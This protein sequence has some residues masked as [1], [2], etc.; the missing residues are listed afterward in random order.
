MR[1]RPV[2]ADVIL[3]KTAAPR[4]AI[5]A[6]TQMMQDGRVAP[7][8]QLTASRNAGGRAVE[9]SLTVTQRIFGGPGFGDGLW[10]RRDGAGRVL[11]RA[12]E[13]SRAGG[14]SAVATGSYE[15]PLAGGRLKANG[16]AR[17]FKGILDDD[18]VL[19][20]SGE[21]YTL[22]VV[23]TFRQVE[24]GLRYERALGKRTTLEAQALQRFNAHDQTNHIRRP[25]VVSDFQE[26]DDQSESVARATVRFKKDE[27]LTLETSGEGALNVLATDTTFLVGGAASPLPNADI[28]VTERRGEVGGLVTWKPAPRYGVTAG[29]R[30]ETST[31]EAER[32]VALTRSL[33][34]LKPR[35]V[36]SWS[37]AKD[38]QIR[39]RVEREIGQINFFNFVAISEF[40]SGTVRAGNP[41]LRPQRAWVGEAVLERQ[42]WD[43]A[44]IVLTARQ[45]ALTDVVDARAVGTAG[46]VGIGNIGDGSETDLIAT[47]TF[48]LKRFGL[49][50]AM[51][52]GTVTRVISRVTDPT[53]GERR[54]IWFN[55]P[56]PL[57]GELHF[58]YD[59]PQRKLNLGFDAF[60]NGP[61]TLYR[62]AGTEHAGVNARLNAF[63]EYRYRPN[64]TI[65]LEGMNVTGARITQTIAYYAGARHVSPL[66]YEDERTLGLRPSVML[67]VRRTLN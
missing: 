41:D 26:A 37:P 61:F 18:A 58:V 20:G 5:Q 45:K 1:G 24:G 33:T 57:Y 19:R 16:S 27:T 40:N 64:L 59:L 10:E 15:I 38:T 21:R 22:D 49:N 67:R 62:P 35:L 3:K 13:K 14:P 55:A 9:G 44:S 51:V 8:L 39:V 42:F 7:E 11:F 25:P 47:L 23:D 60:Y 52:K 36:L 54:M 4:G 30:L 31:L 28:K 65:R 12:D 43:G 32:G 6:Q 48:P 34:Y 66:L 2:I 53:T 50:G 29:L 63:V 46:A 17:W 56:W